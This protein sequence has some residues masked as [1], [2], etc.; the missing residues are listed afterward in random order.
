M[1]DR[2]EPTPE[3]K[4]IGEAQRRLRW[5]NRKAATAAGIS[6]GRWR[7]IVAGYQTPRKG[8]YIPVTDVPAATIARIAEVV[9]VTPAELEGARRPDAADSLRELMAKPGPTSRE[10]IDELRRRLD[11][12]R[13]VMD[14]E[15]DADGRPVRNALIDGLKAEIDRSTTNGAGS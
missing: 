6:E 1:D 13:D 2:P 10:L 11:E 15:L 4:L 3:G 7:Q 14:R 8:V 9:G 12:L 5:S